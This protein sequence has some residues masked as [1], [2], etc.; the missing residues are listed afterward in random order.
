MQS[1]KDDRANPEITARIGQCVTK[2]GSQQKVAKLLGIS[3]PGLGK[4]VSGTARPAFELVAKLAGLADV[5][6]DWIATGREH[7][8]SRD[9][10]TLPLRSV[11][12][13]EVITAP[14]EEWPAI[15]FRRDYLEHYGAH[16]EASFA[17]MVTDADL[18]PRIEITDLV[19][20]DAAVRDLS[21]NGIYAFVRRERLMLLSV[22]AKLDGSVV[23]ARGD[24]TE[25]LDAAAAAKLHVLGRIRIVCSPVM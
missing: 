11:L 14:D 18:S 1:K 13:G 25:Q 19:V 6:L 23:L 22:R 16:P 12:R 3:Q 9:F 17:M 24:D 5:S 7:A 4:W 15:P 8:G 10:I 20:V 21:S 2:L